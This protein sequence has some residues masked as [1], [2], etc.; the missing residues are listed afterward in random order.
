MPGE[1]TAGSYANLGGVE[2]IN[3][4]RTVAYLQ[5]GLRP[6]TLEVHGSCSCENIR[7][8]VGC[9]GPYTQPSTDNAPWF[10]A[11]IPESSR[12]AGFLMTE[13][14]GL[15]STFERPTTETIH[16]GTVLGRSRLSGRTFTWKGLLLGADCCAVT[17]GLRWL[18]KT[19][20]G[21]GAC[22]NCLGE[23]LTFLYCCPDVTGIDDSAFRLA[24]NVALISGPTITDQRKLGCGD[25][26]SGSCVIEVEFSLLATQPF[27]F[28][29]PITMYDCVNV[30]SNGVI[31]VT[32]SLIVCP[33][34]SSCIDV[35]FGPIGPCEGPALPPTASYTNSCFLPGTVRKAV[36]L[37]VPRS[38]WDDL[39]EVVPVITI[40][41]GITPLLY[42]SLGFYSSNSDDPCGD[43]IS[44]PPNCDVICDELQ[45]IAIGANSKFY[46]D[47]RTRT[48]AH[49]CPDGSVWPGERYIA[50][51]FAW[52][53][54]SQF[55]FCLEITY[56]ADSDSIPVDDVCVSLSLVPRTS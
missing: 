32:S 38:S 55:G 50:G 26:C 45:I 16:D 41:T 53:S 2:I 1:S 33:P 42:V 56:P 35:F 29:T 25:S 6:P 36:Y 19:L 12:F 22:Q 17:Y 46:I 51:P 11:D 14:E 30:G 49:I 15:D 7:T 24:K 18:T 34:A 21:M 48:M 20:R 3:D 47:G 13:F 52:P 9:D 10:S 54:F 5:Q 43:L 39:S 37:T 40:E 28:E 44:N 4:A 27:F 8:L 23:D 31:P